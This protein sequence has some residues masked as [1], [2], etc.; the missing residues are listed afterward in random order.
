MMQINRFLVKDFFSAGVFKYLCGIFAF[1]ILSL[2]VMSF[3]DN[4]DPVKNQVIISS[5]IISAKGNTQ[6]LS[7]QDQPSNSFISIPLNS[8]VLPF[9]NDF[10]SNQSYEYNKMKTWGQPYFVLF[11]KIFAANG[12]PLELKYLSVIESDLKGNL[13]SSVDAVGPWQLMPDEAKRFH[14]KTDEGKDERKD[15]Y[16]STEVAAQLLKE[17]HN[18][19]GDWLLAVAAYNCGAGRMKQAIAKAGSD[20]YWK[21]QRYLP[22][23]TRRHVKKYIATDYY[24]EG[25]A[26]FTTMTADETAKLLSTS[27]AK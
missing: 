25:T 20:N 6:N 12:L 14:L 9:V 1:L 26:G 21:L 13:V 8:Q 7:F 18:E 11:D 10:I 2:S 22:E 3:T 23:E 24:F 17:L 27:F 16:K 15:F 5:G 19:F 4:N